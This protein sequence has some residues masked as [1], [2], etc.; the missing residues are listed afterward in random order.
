MLQLKTFENMK[1]WS[2][3]KNELKLDIEFLNNWKQ[4][5]VYP[6]FLIFKIPNFSNKNASLISKRLLLSAIKNPSKELQDA[7]KELS[8]FKNFISKQLC[9]IDFYIF[10]KSI[11]SHNKKLLQK[12]LYTQH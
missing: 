11:T 2:R 1:N 12:S 4:L 8:I 3:K 9:T 6:K 7:L 10:K 5:A